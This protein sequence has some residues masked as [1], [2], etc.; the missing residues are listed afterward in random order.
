M[1][2][3][4]KNAKIVHEF[5]TAVRTCNINQIPFF[6]REVIEAG[7]W[8]ARYE[9]THCFEFSAFRDFITSDPI[10]GCG[11][12]KEKVE[13]LLQSDPDVLRMFRQ[14]FTP[15][16]HIHH[17]DTDNIS[18]S[19]GTSR[20]YT[21]DRLQRTEPELYQR[22]VDKTLPKEQRLSANAAAVLAGFR[23]KPSPMEQIRRLWEKLSH[24]ERTTFLA[25]IREC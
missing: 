2:D 12:T 18:I 1:T 7:A 16:K 24:E 23:N 20:A 10:A 14:A 11:W 21:L 22:V 6:V 8:K 5:K 4:A 19:Y 13:A 9:A 15:E 17:G 25:E 3:L